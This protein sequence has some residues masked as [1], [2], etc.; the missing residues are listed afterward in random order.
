LLTKH[1]LFEMSV[2]EGVGNI[3]LFGVPAPRHDDGEQSG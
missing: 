3:K 1:M 2:K